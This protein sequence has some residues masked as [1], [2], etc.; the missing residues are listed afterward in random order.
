MSVSLHLNT[1]PE[2]LPNAHTHSCY[3]SQQKSDLIFPTQFKKPDTTKYRC[4]SN[5]STLWICKNIW[6][7]FIWFFSSY[8]V[9]S[10]AWARPMEKWLLSKKGKK[11]QWEIQR[12]SWSGWVWVRQGNISRFSFLLVRGAQFCNE[13]IT[14]LSKLFSLL[15]LE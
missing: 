4:K 12:R 1:H 8:L 5:I 6:D 13:L 9:S 14:N 11:M 15:I 7:Y 10:S 2:A 3:N